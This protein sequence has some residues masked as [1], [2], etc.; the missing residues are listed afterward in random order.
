MGIIHKILHNEAPAYLNGIVT[1]NDNNFRNGK[2]LLI[3]KPKNNFHKTSMS[4]GAPKVW[5]DLPDTI[6]N[7]ANND[8]FVNELRNYLVNK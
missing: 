7:I 6:R 4:I 3:G 1:V 8:I 2:K 5:N